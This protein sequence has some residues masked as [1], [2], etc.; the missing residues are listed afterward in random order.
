MKLQRGFSLVE[1]LVVITIIGIL[2]AITI[3]NMTRVR[4]KA[5]ETEVKANLHVIQE[6]IHRYDVDEQEFPAWLIGGDQNSWDVYYLRMGYDMTDPPIFD[7][8]IRYNYVDS[9]PVNPFTG[10]DAGGLYLEW[11]GGDKFTPAS[12][13][14]R[15]GMKGNV[16][17]NSVDDP[18]LSWTNNGGFAD[19]INISGTPLIETYLN[20]G[21]RRALSGESDRYTIMGSFFY[22]SEGPIDMISS[23]LSSGSPTRRDFVYQRYERYILGGFGHETTKGLDVF[24]LEGAGDYAHQP[25]TDNF[26]FDVPLLLPEVFGGGDRDNNPFFPYE[27]S[28]DGTRFYYGAPDGLEDGVVIVLTDSGEDNLDF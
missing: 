3:P 20:Y 28:Q 22:R 6:A 1:L 23:D 26:V 18:Y 21:G 27:P 24:R 11:S 17:N 2:A 9:Y 5:H 19:T 16:M 12:G 10:A 8:L 7:P 15:F 4:N 14:P 13:D 25:D